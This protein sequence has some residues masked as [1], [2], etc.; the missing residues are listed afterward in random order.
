MRS[1]AMGWV[2]VVLAVAAMGATA[3]AGTRRR[4]ARRSKAS[5]GTRKRD[6][7]K[8]VRR[9]EPGTAAKT[10]AKTS[11]TSKTRTPVFRKRRGNQAARIGGGVKDGSLTRRETVRL[12]AEQKKIA[13]TR[14]AVG[15]DGKVTPKERALLQHQQDKANAHIFK[16]RH[17][18]QGEMGPVPEGETKKTWSPG[19]NKRQQNQR[20][21]IKH[22]IRTGKLTKEEAQGIIQQEKALSDL[23]KELKGDGKLTRDERKQLHEELNK[24]SKTIYEEKHDDETA[25]R[26]RQEIRKKIESGEIT[27]AE[28]KDLYKK[29]REAC[30]LRHKLGSDKDLT[31]EERAEI[32]A[33]LE[34]LLGELHE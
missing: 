16:E 30:K 18:K 31:D 14:E 17:D 32:E 25:P 23:E 5:T 3:A 2:L 12:A 4:V 21:R 29:M 33:E 13:A 15:E 34:A 10:N 22:G 11:E 6:V 26:P 1:R 24:L 7:S 20:R 27:K 9:A 8:S 19:V 28:A